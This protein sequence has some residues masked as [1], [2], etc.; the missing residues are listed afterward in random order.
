MWSILLLAF[1]GGLLVW[2]VWQGSIGLHGA[3]VSRADNPVLFW[4]QVGLLSLGVFV[5][6]IA[7]LRGD[8]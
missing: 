1:A 4:G 7:I 3:A 8:L 2:A 6:S 5:M